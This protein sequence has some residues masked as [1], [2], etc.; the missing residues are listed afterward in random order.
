MPARTPEG[1]HDDGAEV[2]ETFSEALDDLKDRGSMVLLVGPVGNEAMYAGCRRFLGDELVEDRRRLFVM[3]DGQIEHHQGAKAT[4][5]HQPPA[6][7]HAINYRT[8]ARSV[9][10]A[11]ASDHTDIPAE[12]VEG[13]LDDLYEHIEDAVE[14]LER[15]ADGFESGE[16]RLCLDSVDA[17]LA[18]NDDEDVLEFVERVESLVHEHCGMA[19]VHLPVDFASAPV[20]RFSSVF[21]AIVEVETGNNAFRQRWHLQDLGISTGWLK[22]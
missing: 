14:R 15:R 7:A 5:K 20:E 11:T 1:K 16:F 21:D 18:H 9:A 12:T 8:Q 6:D 13:D 22:L 4:C 17:L 2:A 3:T 10:T 19:H